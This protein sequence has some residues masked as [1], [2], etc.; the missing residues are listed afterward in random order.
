[1]AAE[2][3]L[4]DEYEQVSFAVDVREVANEVHQVL[5]PN[6]VIA[7][8]VEAHINDEF[9]RV[10]LLD[11]VEKPLRLLAQVLI[12]TKAAVDGTGVRQVRVPE[13]VIWLL[14]K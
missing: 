13:I 1:M 10:L 11:Q 6:L 8:T 2:K 14:P 4:A 12:T 3:V 9:V 7:A 5:E